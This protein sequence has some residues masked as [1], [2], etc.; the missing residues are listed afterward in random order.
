MSGCRCRRGRGNVEK[1]LEAFVKGSGGGCAQKWKTPQSRSQ[2]L[3]VFQT[4]E[5]EGGGWHRRGDRE[6][7]GRGRLRETMAAEP[8]R[9]GAGENGQAALRGQ[10]KGR[11][12]LGRGKVH[13]T[14]ERW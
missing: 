11:S 9:D 3:D 7:G 4:Q 8:R 2:T 1:A 14:G 6:P 12:D 5:V 10:M 13:V